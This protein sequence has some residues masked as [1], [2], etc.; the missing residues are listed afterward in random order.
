VLS[1]CLA[2][3]LA[4][5]PALKVAVPGFTFVNLEPRLGEVFLDRFVN[6]VAQQGVQVTSEK[7]IK[8]VLGL[9][10]Q[11]A[12]LGCDQQD[13]AIELAGALGVDAILVGSL[14][15]VGR[16]YTVN[17]RAIR[18]G[19]GAQLVTATERV[20]SEDA[21]QNWLDQQARA[22]PGQLRLALGLPADEATTGTS[23]VA[24]WIPGIIGGL[25]LIGGGVSLGLSVGE[26]DRLRNGH[27]VEPDITTAATT[28][29]VEQTLGVIGLAAG[30]ALL[31]TSVIWVL[32]APASAVQVSAAPT[33][34][35]F[36]L[37]VIGA[38]P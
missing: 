25:A 16:S 26:A 20:D 1:T 7:D 5:S 13:C 8:Q 10:R 22:L 24:R 30:G 27:L 18:T 23:N 21:L 38:F 12:L 14:A 6:V 17:L 9:E 15:R 11:K 31:A 33:R 32:V 35:G 34:D 37:G 2:V 36:A 28:G 29:N 19:T 3:A 4:A